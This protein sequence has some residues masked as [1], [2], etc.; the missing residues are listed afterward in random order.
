ML[1]SNNSVKVGNNSGGTARATAVTDRN[2][3]PGSTII[4]CD[5]EKERDGA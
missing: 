3:G 2:S 1:L 4:F 5:D